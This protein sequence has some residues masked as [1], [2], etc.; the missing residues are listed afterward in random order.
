MCKHPFARFAC[1]HTFSLDTARPFGYTS[2]MRARILVSVLLV[3]CGGGGGNP[4]QPDA[5]DGPKAQCKDGIDNDGDGKIDY[6][7]DPGCFAPQADDEHDDCPGPTCPQCANG[8][9][10]D[11]N[12][13]TDYPSDPG[14]ESAADNVELAYNPV[15][16]GGGMM[17]KQLPATGQ[18][19]GMLAAGSASMIVSPCGGGG[20]AFAIAYVMNVIEPRIVVAT[21]DMPG[22]AT[23]TVVDIRAANCQD[24]AAEIAC[25]DDISA[26]NNKSTVTKS[27]A[28]GVYFIVVQGHDSGAV[29]AYQLAVSFYKP[30]GAGC[31]VAEDCFP[32]L[33]CRV[34][35]NQTTKICAR[36][37]CDDGL[38]D[39]GDGKHDYPNDPGCAAPDDATENDT[40][41]SGAGCPVCG[42]GTDNDADTR[43]DFPADFGCAAASGTSE[44]FCSQDPDAANALITAPQTTGTL[45]GKAKNIAFACQSNSGLDMTFPIR[46]DVPVA[47]LVIDTEGSTISDTVLGLRDAQC[48]TSIA[49][50]DDGGTGLLSMMTATNVAA[51]VYAINVAAYGTTTPN[52]FKLNV[53]GTVA[54]MTSCTSSLFTSG[55]LV[56]PTGTTCT[57]TP[58]KCQ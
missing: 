57:G 15:A 10:D 41:P 42:D 24:P 18:D 27:L 48:G 37:V 33:Y 46:L 32:G 47:T 56:C 4:T 55:V 11:G 23:D 38:D 43:V 58:A 25:S 16:C 17:I 7:A 31:A 45:V 5:D 22:T 53:K 19:T 2:A 28:K 35:A 39:D 29:G 34:P 36:A 51:G 14:C 6:P 3:S 44:V 13:M 9:D 8:V 21:T 49:C 26:T 40:C 54:P 1:Q 20:G 52:T 50:D 30:E 12:D